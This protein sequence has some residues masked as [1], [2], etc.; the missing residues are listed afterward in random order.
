MI[1]RLFA[2][3][4]AL[5]FSSGAQAVQI[6]W[7]IPGAGCVPSDATTKFNR[8]LVGNGTVQHATGNVGMI[9]LTCPITQF[10]T[11]ITSWNL[12]L[13]YRDSTGAGPS[14]FV[15]AQLY[16][17]PFHGGAPVL[18]TTANSNSSASTAVGYVA[19]PVFAHPFDF[20]AYSY[21]VR[22][23]LKRSS[24]SETV[25]FRSLMLELP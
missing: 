6:S 22:V 11:D 3:L 21:W 5:C 13:T 14:A 2:L 25:I 23:E 8:A 16:R 18:M 24:T 17:M 20:S 9:V 4:A 1:I 19:S 7:S 12:F 15:Q 10:T